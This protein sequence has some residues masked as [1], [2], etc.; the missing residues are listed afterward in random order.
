M[1]TRRRRLGIGPTPDQHDVGGA[2]GTRTS[3]GFAEEIETIRPE[4]N[5]VM[6]RRLPQHGPPAP[7]AAI[8]V[9]L[10]DHQAQLALALKQEAARTELTQAISTAHQKITALRRD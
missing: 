2:P 7:T 10:A 5:K 6:R 3:W 4:L 9:A 1:S 8:K